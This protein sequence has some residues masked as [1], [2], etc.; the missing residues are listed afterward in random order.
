VSGECL[1]SWC[2]EAR[3]KARGAETAELRGLAAYDQ[4]RHL[5]PAGLRYLR[6]DDQ[7]RSET[8]GA[9]LNLAPSPW[10]EVR[11]MYSETHAR[12]AERLALRMRAA[13]E[14]AGASCP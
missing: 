5:V 4:A 10:R 7:A 1:C 2:V 6:V 12:E 9:L 3:L 13:R 8:P 14:R 11:S